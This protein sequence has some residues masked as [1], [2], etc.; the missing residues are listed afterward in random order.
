MAGVGPVRGRWTRRLP[1][2]RGNCRRRHSFLVVRR[3]TNTVDITYSSHSKNPSTRSGNPAD[4]NLFIDF[5][6]MRNLEKDD[7]NRLRA[8]RIIAK[9]SLL[10]I[11]YQ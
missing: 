5:Y 8:I 2:H 4:S 6:G 1:T 9:K 3:H 10:I 7:G 11:Y